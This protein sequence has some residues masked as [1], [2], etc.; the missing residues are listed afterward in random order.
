MLNKLLILIFSSFIILNAQKINNFKAKDINYKSNS[1]YNLKGQKLTIVDFWETGCK[2]C[3]QAIPKLNNLHT[4]F[5]DKGVKIIGINVDSPR[6]QAKIKAFSKTYKMKYT[7]LRDPNSEIAND[8]N[9]KSYPTL[10]I[11]NSNNEIA[12]THNGFRPGDEV[13]IRD[14]IERL[15]IGINEN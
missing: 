12:Y 8:F 10:Y 2:P 11:I 6:N 3:I 9:V 1:F 14:E 5:G 7:L 13:K 4:E 15:L